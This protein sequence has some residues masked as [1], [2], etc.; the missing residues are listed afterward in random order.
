MT[1]EQNHIPTP[2]A[3]PPPRFVA[4]GD[5]SETIPLL[6]AID[7]GGKIYTEITVC[8]PDTAAIDA[9]SARIRA[10][11]GAG[12]DPMKIPLPLYDA[13]DEVILA[14]DPDDDDRLSEV[15]ERFLP[16]RFRTTPPG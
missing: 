8:R 16:A 11:K 7:F 15:A 3:S 10:A 2:S 1:D 5:R 6:W 12:G 13:P 4:A 9:W 14:L